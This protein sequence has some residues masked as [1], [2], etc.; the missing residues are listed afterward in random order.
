LQTWAQISTLSDLAAAM[1]CMRLVST[2]TWKVDG[3]SIFKPASFHFP[4]CFYTNDDGTTVAQWLVGLGINIS[5]TVSH[6]RQ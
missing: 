4:L 1:L 2:D 6:K 3:F 5:T